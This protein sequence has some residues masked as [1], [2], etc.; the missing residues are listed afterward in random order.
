MPMA[1]ELKTV[2]KLEKYSIIKGTMEEKPK[3]LVVD[4]EPDQCIS[5]KNYFSRRNFLVFTAESGEEA[6]TA[7][8]EK[9]PDLVLLDI[10]LAGSMSGK[11]VLKELRQYDK[12][13]KVS[14]VTGDVLSEQDIKEITNLGIVE[15]ISKP[16]VLEDLDK[17]IRK[18]LE[19]SYPKSMRYEELKPKQEPMKVSL[20]RIAHDLS[21]VTGDIANKCELYILD[22]EEG[23]KKDKSEKERLNESISILKSVLK[24][25]ERLTDIVKKL[26]SLAKKEL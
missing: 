15:L 23:L 18:V 9:R 19:Q 11:D 12:D 17:V 20:R 16:V 22:T 1:K 3:L 4:D 14:I 7:I 24:Q 6:L 10:K 8:K 25:A 26:S 21:N 5:I 13:T 2:S